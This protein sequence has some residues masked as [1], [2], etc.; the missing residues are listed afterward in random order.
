MRDLPYQREGS[1]FLAARRAAYLGDDPGL[2]KS[3]QAI[4]AADLRGAERVLVVSPASLKVNWAREFA[5]FSDRQRPVCM[6]KVRDAASVP[7]HGPS[8]T[9]INY[10]IARRVELHRHLRDLRWD[11]LIADEA[12]ALKNPEATQ[13]RAML[14]EVGLVQTADAVY[15]MSG[16]PLPN[17][18][19]ELYPVLAALY[20]QAT[21]GMGYEKWLRHHCYVRETAY[22]LRPVSNKPTIQQLR[23]DTADFLIRRKRADVLT[24]LP[25]LRTGVLTVENDRAL[26]TVRGLEAEI[27]PELLALLNDEDVDPE[28]LEEVEELPLS[29]L[30]RL[31][32]QAK[33]HAL[34][35][36]I[37]GELDGGV[38]QIVL[39]C[40]HHDTMDI[41]ERGLARFG[42]AR[43]DGKTKNVQGEVDRF[44]QHDYST[45]C[46][47][48]IG[49]IQSAGTGH[50]LTTAQDMIIVEPS[51]VPGEN[52]QAMLRIHRIGQEGSCLV[53]Y[54][55]LAGSL[56]EAIMGSAERKAANTAELLN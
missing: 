56:D 7:R 44:T 5:K 10:D 54:A 36:V 4:D 35:D 43:V 21:Y 19:G 1:E 37:A 6:P 17:H 16:T 8:L 12:H 24:D 39:M 27:P 31:Y 23:A 55:A 9:I 53:R 47:V 3:K 20:P 13:T 33:A 45:K 22:G 28:F 38:E 50:T 15:P 46:R 34:V 42:T 25:P 11:V 30:R 26:E 18:V 49:Q 51:W 48:F 52:V 14:G 29:T 2:G 41:L 40:W 32:G